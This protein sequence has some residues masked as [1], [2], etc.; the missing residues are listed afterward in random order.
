[1]NA[2][3]VPGTEEILA[4]TKAAHAELLGAIGRAVDAKKSLDIATARA[5]EG[6]PE[7]AAHVAA[8]AEVA[9]LNAK[10][11]ALSAELRQKQGIA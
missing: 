2:P 1:M 9:A 6:L 4:R 8:K 5:V 10:Y 7:F 3:L 11:N